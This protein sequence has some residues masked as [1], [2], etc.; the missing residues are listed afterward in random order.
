VVVILCRESYKFHELVRSAH[1]FDNIDLGSFRDCGMSRFSSFV[2][3][4]NNV[5]SKTLINLLDEFRDSECEVPRD[6]VY[7]LVSLCSDFQLPEINYDQT[8]EDLAY[9]ILKRSDDPVCVCSALLVAQTLGL[10]SNEDTIPESPARPTSKTCID[11]DLKDLKFARHVMLCNDE[12]QSWSHYK[13]VGRDMFGHEHLFS[14]F[15]TAFETLMNELQVRAMKNVAASPSSVHETAPAYSET[16]SLLKMMDQEHVSAMLDGFGSA[17]TIHAHNTYPDI[18]TLQIT[19]QLLVELIPHAVPLCPRVAPY[20]GKLKVRTSDDAPSP[21]TRIPTS[22]RTHA[23]SMPTRG[24]IDLWPQNSNFHKID[25]M[26]P[27]KTQDEEGPVSRMRLSRV[28][29]P[30]FTF[31]F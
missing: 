24:S 11:F 5:R 7:S 28:E 4:H 26:E 16:P 19:L 3:D 14:N 25:S 6:R 30:E 9:D 2:T 13:L 15:C 23:M 20:K 12:I 21:S 27:G 29:S 18:S 22:N 17:L 10:D 1:R 8:G 31:T